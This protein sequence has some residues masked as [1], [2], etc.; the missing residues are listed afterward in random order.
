MQKLV[1]FS[2]LSTLQIDQIYK[3]FVSLFLNTANLSQ[4]FICPHTV[5][6]NLEKMEYEKR[7]CNICPLNN[8]SNKKF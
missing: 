1:E 5:K 6:C 7:L 2:E 4:G 8:I 3:M